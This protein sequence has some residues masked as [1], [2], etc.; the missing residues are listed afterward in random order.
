MWLRLACR[1]RLGSA[2]TSIGSWIAELD[3]ENAA[4]CVVSRL[5]HGR[6]TS[7]IRVVVNDRCD[8]IRLLHGWNSREWI[9][10]DCSSLC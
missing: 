1:S 3:R 5:Y 8:S 10:D 4:F 7:L 6:C 9:L 2:D